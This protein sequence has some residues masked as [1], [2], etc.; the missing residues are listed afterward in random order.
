M[1]STTKTRSQPLASPSKPKRFKWLKR[2]LSTCLLLLLLLIS[3]AIALP[4]ALPWLLQQQGIDFEWHN[5]QWQRSGFS[6]SKLQLNI[7]STDTQL[8]Q[9]K[10]DNVRLNWA[11][12]AFPIQR[13]QAERLQANWPLIDNEAHADKSKL[14]LPEALLKWLPQHIEV[15]EIDAN[16]AGLG[17]I[18]GSLNLQASAHGLLWQPTFIQTQLTLE[19]MQGTWLDSIPEEFQPTQL[20]VHIT[21]HPDHQDNATG[22]QLL[23]VDIHSQGPMRLQLNGLLD[24]QQEPNWQGAISKAQLFVQ[25]DALAH[26]AFSAEQLQARLYFSGQAD[27]ERFAFTL[28]EHSS[29]EAHNLQLPDIGQAQ[30]VTAH[31]VGLSIE[32]QS[33]APEQIKVY[34][35]FNLH[36]EQLS[37]EQLHTQNWDFSGTLDGQLPGLELTGDIIGQHGLNLSSQIS[38]LDNSVQG[39][40][41]LTDISFAQSNPL[42]KTFKD[43]PEAVSLNGGQLR[44]HID[45]TAPEAGPIQLSLNSHASAINGTINNSTLKN[46]S[47]EFSSKLDLQQTSDWQATLDNAQLLVKLDALTDPTLRAEQLQAQTSFKGQ[48]NSQSFTLSFDKNSSIQAHKLNLPDIGQAQKATVQLH[49]LSLQGRSTAPHKIDLRSPVTAHF[50]KLSAEQLH[51]QDWDFTGTLSGEL[52]KLELKGDLSNQQGLTLNSHIR[53]LDNSV[54]GNATLKD[55]FFKAGNPLQATFKDWPELVSFNSGKLE[56]SIDFTQPFSGPLKINLKGN[57][58]GLNGIINRS[59]LKNLS[60]DFNGKLAGKTLSLTLPNLSIEQL[61]PGVSVEAIQLSNAHY[62]AS[63]AD[64]LKGVVDWNNVQANLLKGRVWLKAQQLDL[65]KAQKQQLLLQVE[66]LELQELFRVY[67]TEGL[68]GKGTID[69]QLPLYIDHGTV[70]IESGQLH[71][72]ESGVLQFQSD[73]IQA[74]GK[75]NPAMSLVADALDDF[76]FN[77]LSSDLNYDQSG[78]LLLNVRL[79]GQNPDVEKGR[80]IHLNVNLEEDIPALL[81]SIQLS[82][83][84][85]EIIQKRVRERLENR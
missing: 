29:L 32:G 47:F 3:A 42:Q 26:P 85:S 17:R 43:W 21:T 38:L 11:W 28:N 19:N 24:L 63:L 80:P 34:S 69:G 81:A 64:P 15:Q 37:A 10:L 16:I 13:L 23:T 74:L 79:E 45:F 62:S 14:T 67:P 77:L 84:V 55:I 7:P 53:L 8:K 2:L 1:T 78:K 5:P 33:N 66:G 30:Q 27:P 22:Q 83:Q 72:R 4:Y 48:A 36:I 49:N 68:S 9:L 40:A 73:K 50:E 12:Q 18:Q 56:S 70:Y 58:S 20:S 25:L 46:L 31:L 41:S 52:A 54:Q 76:H 71:A 82:G 44:G 65:G 35:P 60:L 75:T 59:E 61:D 51:T 57:A 39:R 6:A